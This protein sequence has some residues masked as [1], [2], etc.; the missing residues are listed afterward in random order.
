AESVKDYLVKNFGI[1]P[2]RLKTKGFGPA[3]S[4]DTNE[5]PEGKANNRRVM[6][7]ISFFE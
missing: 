7:V 4:I 1:N 6:A 3:R 2:Q 5:T